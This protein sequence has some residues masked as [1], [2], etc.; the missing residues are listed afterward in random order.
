MP[1]TLP[2]PSQ[3]NTNPNECITSPASASDN[4]DEFGIEKPKHLDLELMAKLTRKKQQRT[5]AESS[6]DENAIAAGMGQ[7]SSLVKEWNRSGLL[8]FD[9]TKTLNGLLFSPLG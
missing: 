1:L 2:F 6:D 8:A 4:E 3:Y 7:T 5:V 9:K